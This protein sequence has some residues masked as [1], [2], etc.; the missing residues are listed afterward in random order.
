[1]RQFM[2]SDKIIEIIFAVIILGGMGWMVTQLVT[3]S[4]TIGEIKGEVQS[5][6]KRVDNIANA[7]PDLK[8]KLAQEELSKNIEMALVITRPKTIGDSLVLFIT[9]LFVRKNQVLHSWYPIV[10]ENILNLKLNYFSGIANKLRLAPVYFTELNNWSI[11]VGKPTIAPS[12][13]YSELSFIT[14]KYSDQFIND[15]VKEFGEGDEVPTRH[16]YY[17]DWKSLVEELKMNSDAYANPP[18][19]TKK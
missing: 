18:A 3:I 16:E 8:I 7:L 19:F 9:H 1:M 5:T 2:K 11:Q 15:L 12:Y 6:T 4:G 17:D 14:R 10:P 13:A